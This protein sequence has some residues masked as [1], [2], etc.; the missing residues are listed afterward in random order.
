[1]LNY[2]A[3]RLRINNYILNLFSSILSCLFS[4]FGNQIFLLDSGCEINPQCESTLLSAGEICGKFMVLYLF[5][6]NLA[7]SRLSPK[8]CGRF[9]EF[10]HLFIL[11]ERSVFSVWIF[12]SGSVAFP[13]KTCR[14]SRWRSHSWLS[15]G[16]NCLVKFSFV[17]LFGFLRKEKKTRWVRAFAR[18]NYY[19]N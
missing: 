13:S 16:K 3:W 2:F 11:F 12:R 4:S 5:A 7:S 17:S 1:M 9:F 15:T 18:R 19:S 10:Y 6:Y 14:Y 8:G